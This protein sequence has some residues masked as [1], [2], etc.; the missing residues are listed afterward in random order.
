MNPCTP[1]LLKAQEAR[2][3]PLEHSLAPR[4]F[5]TTGFVRINALLY[6]AGPIPV[7]R[8]QLWAMAKAGLFPAPVKLSAKVT[9]WSVDAVRAWMREREHPSQ[10]TNVDDRHPSEQDFAPTT[11]D[12]L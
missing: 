8:A 10:S 12:L 7:S 1:A 9:A 6:P 5:P 4:E 11:S 3:S 2:D